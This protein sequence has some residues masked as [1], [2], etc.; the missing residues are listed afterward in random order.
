MSSVLSI[1][2]ENNKSN[3]E[4]L[5]SLGYSKRSGSVA[6]TRP[7]IRLIPSMK[8]FWEDSTTKT[9]TSSYILS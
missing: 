3:L 8:W 5:K 6:Y 9:G 1:N 4:M 7:T 2:I